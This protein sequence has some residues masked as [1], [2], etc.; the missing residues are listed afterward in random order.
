M[1]RMKTKLFLG[2]A[3][4]CAVSASGQIF[5]PQFKSLQVTNPSALLGFPIVHASN[6]ASRVRVS[7]DE[8]A[9]DVSYLR[10]RLV[11]CNS[12]WQP[13]QISDMEYASGFNQAEVTDYAFSEHTL[14]HY[15]NYVIDFPDE[16][17]QP[18]LSG[19]YLLQVYPEDNP[20]EVLLQAPFMVSEDRV[21]IDAK[22]SS[23]TDVD[24]NQNHQQLEV[25]VNL[26]GVEIDNPYNDLKLVI[27]QNGDPA[28]RRVLTKPLRTSGNR[29]IYEHQ[30]ELIFPAG[31]EF[32]RFDLANLHYPGRGVERYDFIDP[33]YHAT[34]LPDRSREYER[35]VYDEDQSGRYYI[36]EINAS[37]P[38]VNADYVMTHFTLEMPR[39]SGPVYI[40]GDL[41]L[42]ERNE[43]TRME[44]D[45]TLGA[46]VKGLLLKQGMYNYRYVTPSASGLNPIEGDRY[47]TRNEYLLLLYYTPVGAR[48]DRLLSTATLH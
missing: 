13:T 14:T 47:E 20:D 10:Y 35:Y 5:D 31:N 41:T 43:N 44:Y 39:R 27:I 3:L 37:D 42:H 18:L 38:A 30:K 1:T 16:R 40:D 11:H 21:G 36:D 24:Y 17:L 6:P 2:A 22:M 26:E 46:Y 48:Y 8:L 29:L 4:L 15:V 23:R 45:E 7:F 19:N 25:T 9:E 34:L 28:S 12:D 33:L 32:R